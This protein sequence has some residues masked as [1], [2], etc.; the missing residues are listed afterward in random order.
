MDILTL[1]HSALEPVVA[2]TPLKSKAD[3]KKTKKSLGLSFDQQVMDNS[4][5]NISRYN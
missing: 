3:K 1:T 5:Y 4:V 2:N